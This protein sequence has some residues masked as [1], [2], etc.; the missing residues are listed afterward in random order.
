[1]IHR[2]VSSL[3]L[4][5]QLGSGVGGSKL[6]AALGSSTSGIV[7][8]KKV[9]THIHT[10]PISRCLSLPTQSQIHITT[11][12]RLRTP[13]PNFPAE[14]IDSCAPSPVSLLLGQKCIC[15]CGCV[16]VC[17]HVCLSFYMWWLDVGISYNVGSS[18]LYGKIGLGPTGSLIH[19]RLW[20]QASVLLDCKNEWESM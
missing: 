11:L 8:I 20:L 7:I 15:G 2:S 9:C 17:N 12:S 1:M 14:M 3:S 5:K 18:H 16:C 4:V 19:F 10:H 6:R 13:P